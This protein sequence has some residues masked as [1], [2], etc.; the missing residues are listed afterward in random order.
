[1]RSRERKL[2]LDRESLVTLKAEQLANVDGGQGGETRITC[3]SGCANRA[4]PTLAEG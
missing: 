4:C 3:M 2:S 1:M